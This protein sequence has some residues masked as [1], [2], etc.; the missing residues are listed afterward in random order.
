MDLETA[1][2]QF[3]RAETNLTRLSDVYEEIV[4]L[5]PEGIVFAGSSPEGRRHAELC[6]EFQ[7]LAN[8]LPA[9]EG[10]RITS[11]PDSVDEIAES[12]MGAAEL[13]EPEYTIQVERA[14]GEPGTEIDAYRHRFS[15]ARRELVRNRL[16]ELVREVDATLGALGDAPDPGDKES[17]VWAEELKEWSTGFEWEPLETRVTEIRRLLT[18]RASTGARWGD[19]IRHLSFG[20]PVDLRDIVDFDWPSVREDIEQQLYAEHEP[21]P[22]EV[23]DLGE[24]AAEEP[25][26]PVTTQLEWERLDDEMFER[27][28]FNLLTGSSGYENAEWLT[29]TKAPD[30]GRDLSVERVVE[31]ELAG[32]QR[33]R[34][35]VQCRHT[36][37]SSVAP[38]E[39]RDIVTKAELWDPPFDAVVIATTGRFTSDAVAWIERHNLKERIQVSMWPNSRLELLLANRPELVEEFG[40]RP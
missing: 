5:I 29:K 6:R 25:H 37:S 3:D 33:T 21:L 15:K 19:L 4:S 13:G 18:G 26:G 28:I 17:T 23:D 32:P 38:A 16:R 40:L 2:R 24:V 30:R 1:L 31:D 14:I 20:E 35:M 8:A 9:I 12:R 36:L 7:D 34:V 22:V 27:L 10:F 39:A 11:R